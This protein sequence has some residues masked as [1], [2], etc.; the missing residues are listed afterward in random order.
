MLDLFCVLYRLYDKSNTGSL[1][2][3]DFSQLHAF[4]TQM[5]QSFSHFDADRSGELNTNEVFNSLTHAG[6]CFFCM[7]M[8][9][10]HS[11]EY[12]VFEH[13]VLWARGELWT[14]SRSSV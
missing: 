8:S 3:N 13:F 12:I 7:D 11:L 4:L 9:G 1:N 14:C 10:S 2:F 6:K 5:Q